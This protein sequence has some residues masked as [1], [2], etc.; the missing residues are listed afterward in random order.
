MDPSTVS[1]PQAADKVMVRFG[2]YAGKRGTIAAVRQG[3]TL[4]ISLARDG[5]DVETAVSEVRNFS[6]AARKAWKTAPSRRVGRPPGRSVSRVS[7]TL[8]IDGAL[9]ERFR[10]LEQGGRLPNRS[11]FFENALRQTLG[12]ALE[13]E[14]DLA[15]DE[16]SSPDTSCQFHPGAKSEK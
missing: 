13:H 7:I 4:V 11:Q 2:R 6:A 10:A 16:V 12:Q 1:L 3:G 14:R 15:R 9:W 8:R 5:K